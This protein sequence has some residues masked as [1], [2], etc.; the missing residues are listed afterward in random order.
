MNRRTA[1]AWALRELATF[2][3]GLAHDAEEGAAGLER[4]EGA[5]AARELRE[6]VAA[7]H[8]RAFRL[9]RSQGES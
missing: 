5:K 9:E 8:A 7:M 4:T 2:A 3:D 1:R 6:L